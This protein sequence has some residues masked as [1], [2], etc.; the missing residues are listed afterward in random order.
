M[1]ADRQRTCLRSS[2]GDDLSDTAFFL[3][4]VRLRR[5]PL[6]WRKRWTGAEG[7]GRVERG[8]GVEPV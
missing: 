5:A 4:G 8:T 2:D 7:D 3:P 1:N 6:V